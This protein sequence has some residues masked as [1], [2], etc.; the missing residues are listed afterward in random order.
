ML[1]IGFVFN[2]L[3]VIVQSMFSVIANASPVIAN[4][5]KQSQRDYYYSTGDCFGLRHRND[6]VTKRNQNN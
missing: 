3:I 6:E 2:F 1:L 4:E 5:V